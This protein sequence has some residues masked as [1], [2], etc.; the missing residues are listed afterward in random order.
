MIH[1]KKLFLVTV[2]IL[3]AGIVLFARR[4]RP[5][6]KTEPPL[7]PFRRP[8][9]PFK[10]PPPRPW[11]KETVKET[12]DLEAILE[13]FQ[14]NKDRL[15]GLPATVVGFAIRAGTDGSGTGKVTE[16]ALPKFKFTPGDV[17]VGFY[18]KQAKRMRPELTAILYKTRQISKDLEEQFAENDLIIFE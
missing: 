18:D 10:P 9:P 5:L 7:P 16:E 1:M 4:R 11:L 6:T 2:V 12:L 3:V 13:W 14:S 8:P 17:L 15:R